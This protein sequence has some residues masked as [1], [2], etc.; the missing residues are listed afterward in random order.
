MRT[1]LIGEPLNASRSV[2]SIAAMPFK[3]DLPEFQAALKKHTA[4]TAHLSHMTT[5]R[6]GSGQFPDVVYWLMLEPELLDALA[7]DSRKLPAAVRKQM[8]EKVFDQKTPAK[9]AKAKKEK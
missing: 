2:R 3:I 9:T 1:T 7:A 6:Y 8:R 5:W 4:M